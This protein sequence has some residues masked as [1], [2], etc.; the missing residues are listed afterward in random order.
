MFDLSIREREQTLDSSRKTYID[1]LRILSTL[2][3]VMLHVAATNWY[4]T[5]VSSSAW[6]ALNFY[7]SIVRW[8]VPVFL[9]ISGALFL[10]KDEIPVK[11]IYGKYVLRMVIAFFFWS[12]VY[13]LF[14]GTSAVTQLRGLASVKSWLQ[15]IN[16]HYHMW[17][18]PMIAGIYMCLPILKQIVQS[19]KITGYFLAISFVSWVLLP[20][21]A[22]LVHDFVYG[23]TGEI[24]TG[25]YNLFLSTGLKMVMN[26]TFY[27]VL[28]Y[29]VSQYKF[30]KT[31]RQIIY[32]LGVCGFAFTIMVS[33]YVSV[34]GNYP[35]SNYYDITG[36]NVFLESL[37][38]FELYKN[39]S[40][41]NAKINALASKISKCCFGAYC[42]HL[43][44]VEGLKKNGVDALSVCSPVISVPV[45]SLVIFLISLVISGILNCIPKINKYIV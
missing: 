2:A 31:I 38:V 18:I 10:E 35:S 21:F 16:G 19:K 34:R 43:L 33:R 7:D 37:A 44:I 25:L 30:G 1:H 3:I 13:Y 4:T 27:F 28:G 15:I 5:D 12:F 14:S 32:L 23:G 24:L 9:M 22:T 6:S 29:A 8:G 40:F 20:H 11:K 39:L 42:V 41:S 26:Y 36:V 17:F 45:L